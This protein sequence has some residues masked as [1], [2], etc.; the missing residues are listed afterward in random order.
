MV[1]SFGERHRKKLKTLEDFVTSQASFQT[2]A[3]ISHQQQ[4]KELEQEQKDHL[5]KAKVPPLLPNHSPIFPQPQ[6]S[7]GSLETN[8]G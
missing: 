5:L 8:D 7:L 4:I 6:I 2:E 1:N 3:L